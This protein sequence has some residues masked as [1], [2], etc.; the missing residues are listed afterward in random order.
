MSLNERTAF[1]S[2][3]GVI[4]ED[5]KASVLL[6]A[7]MSDD[8]YR[9]LAEYVEVTAPDITFDELVR[10]A[11]TKNNNSRVQEDGTINRR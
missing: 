8:L 6:R 9:A 11:C 7:L 3:I 10:L 1:V 5:Y 4:T 2:T